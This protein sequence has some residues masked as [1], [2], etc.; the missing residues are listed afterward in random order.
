MVIQYK[1]YSPKIA[2]NTFIAPNSSVIGRCTIGE[3]V[4]VWFNA[5]IRADVNEIVIGNNVNIQ[6]GSVLHCDHDHAVEIA[7]NVTIGHNAIIHGCT[8]GNNC[9]IGMG[10]TILDG[11]SIGENCIVGANA[12]VTSGKHIPGGSLI[13]GSPAKVVRALSDDE[14]DGIKKSIAGYVA[15]SKEYSS[16]GKQV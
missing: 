4:S 12:L 8:I 11:A 7:D 6:D 2:N 14:I 5:V 9:I 1:N 16:D 13:I 3:N 15:L 10:T